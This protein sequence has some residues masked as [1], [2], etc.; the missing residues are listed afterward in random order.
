MSET[1]SARDKRTF[2]D[3]RSSSAELLYHASKRSGRRPLALA[4]EYF[5]LRCSA[6]RISFPEYV[7]FGLYDPGM[8]DQDRR[9]FISESLHWPMTRQCCDLTWL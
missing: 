8:D 9:R 1:L 5:K 2:D 4:A 7:Q 3:L 6:G